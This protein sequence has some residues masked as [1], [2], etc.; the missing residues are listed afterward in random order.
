MLFRERG[1]TLDA[2]LTWLSR[3]AF[4][5]S[6][7]HHG[8]V[9]AAVHVSALSS[10][11]SEM[12]CFLDEAWP[13]LKEVPAASA[14]LMH[15]TWS[16]CPIS[17]Y[18]I[19][20]LI[21]RDFLKICLGEIHNVLPEMSTDS[22]RMTRHIMEYQVLTDPS[23]L[24][25]STVIDAIHAS[26]IQ[27]KRQAAEIMYIWRFLIDS[28]LIDGD[29]VVGMV[30]PFMAEILGRYLSRR[31]RKRVCLTAAVIARHHHDISRGVP[32]DCFFGILMAEFVNP[33][34]LWAATFIAPHFLP[35]LSTIMQSM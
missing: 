31:I 28:Q 2:L 27:W 24:K 1:S 7:A 34:G 22:I 10:E 12:F 11:I 25:I 32:R 30:L 16:L 26:P 23:L 8:H 3:Y 33:T 9:I 14:C 5:Y 15:F 6:V 20:Q 4:E 35:L 18:I 17:D 13:V 21:A 19:G 29:L